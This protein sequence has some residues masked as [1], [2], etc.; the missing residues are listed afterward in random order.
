MSF[1]DLLGVQRTASQRQIQLAYHKKM[2][3]L[4]PDRNPT[5]N[6][7]VSKMISEAC[8]KLN[9]AHAT[10]GDPTLRAAYDRSLDAAFRS[11]GKSRQKEQRRTSST[12]DNNASSHNGSSNTRKRDFDSN[13]SG[14]SKKHKSNGMTSDDP[15]YA[16]VY[17]GDVYNPQTMSS[18]SLAE[19]L[20]KGYV[21]LLGSHVQNS[22]SLVQKGSGLIVAAH[23]HQAATFDLENFQTNAVISVVNKAT[24][25]PI[26]VVDLTFPMQY[27]DIV[28]IQNRIVQY[29]NLRVTKSTDAL[30]VVFFRDVNA[31]STAPTAAT[32]STNGRET[33]NFCTMTTMPFSTTEP[34]RL[35]TPA[36]FDDI[37]AAVQKRSM[38]LEKSFNLQTH[39]LLRVTGDVTNIGK[40][41]KTRNLRVCNN[42]ESQLHNVSMEAGAAI[43]VA[44]VNRETPD[45]A[46]AYMGGSKVNDTV[47]RANVTNGLR[48]QAINALNRGE[49]PPYLRDLQFSASDVKTKRETIAVLFRTAS[50]K[51]ALFSSLAQAVVNLSKENLPVG[52]MRRV[53]NLGEEQSHCSNAG[54]NAT[55][56]GTTPDAVALLRRSVCP[57]GTGYIHLRPIA[58]HNDL[59]VTSW[60]DL[61]TALCDKVLRVQVQQ[62]VQVQVQMQN[63]LP[64]AQAQEWVTIE[65]ICTDGLA[66]VVFAGEP[67]QRAKCLIEYVTTGAEETPE[68]ALDPTPD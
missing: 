31:N 6:A 12:S 21:K 16:S 37:L 40:A 30:G 41:G 36:S 9:E 44:V 33:S 61:K 38:Q 54:A 50:E 23:S 4:H 1:Y 3:D 22:E 25:V 14:P 45:S 68:E 65:R 60:N 55:D 46:I 48:F 53:R 8:Q 11:E 47:E 63:A 29:K 62:K 39:M 49:T 67:K 20:K 19:L 18:M 13:D 2:L 52:V 64:M 10:L 7:T 28:D 66:L 5:V 58:A 24:A 43:T 42:N 35:D 17:M 26:P 34:I 56:A 27:S 51:I 32:S 15:Y 57:P 59:I